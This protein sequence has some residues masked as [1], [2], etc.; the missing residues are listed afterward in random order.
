MGKCDIRVSRVGSSP[1]FVTPFLLCCSPGIQIDTLPQVPPS[2]RSYPIASPRCSRR[3]RV[4]SRHARCRSFAT[5]SFC[6]LHHSGFVLHNRATQEV[7]TSYLL[8]YLLSLIV[9]RSIALSLA[10]RFRHVVRLSFLHKVVLLSFVAYC[11][12]LELGRLAWLC[13]MCTYA[14]FNRNTSKDYRF[15]LLSRSGIC[16]CD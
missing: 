13:P 4:V 3:R 1:T 8:C 7:L 11:I 2:C 5:L 12:I 16:M 9:Q 14:P 10:C 15:S 6:P